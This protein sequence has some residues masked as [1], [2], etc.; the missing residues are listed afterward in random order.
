LVLGKESPEPT[1]EDKT[2]VVVARDDRP[3]GLAGLLAPL[4]RYGINMTRLESRPSPEGMWAYVFFIDLLGHADDPELKRA[5]GEM[6]QLASLL[7]ILGAYPR[8]VV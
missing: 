5:L 4:A 1:G 8:S 3:G 7:K 6:E 2:S